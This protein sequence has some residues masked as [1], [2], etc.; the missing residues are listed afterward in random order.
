NMKY[1]LYVVLG[2]SLLGCSTPNP[3]AKA[4]TAAYNQVKVG[5]TR[6]QVF[7]LLGPPKTTEP[8]DD[9]DHCKIAKWGI[10][11][12]AHGWGGW[13]VTFSGD[14]VTDVAESPLQAMVW[15]SVSH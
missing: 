3:N 10:P 7:E 15:G 1:I 2:I 4:N 13:K 12:D 11:H 8:A 5:M 6:A 14:T 9:V